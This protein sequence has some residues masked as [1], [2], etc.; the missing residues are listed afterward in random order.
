MKK[1]TIKKLNLNKTVISQLS[2]EEQMNVRGGQ[3]EVTTSFG[4]CTGFLC[5]EPISDDSGTCCTSAAQES[6]APTYTNPSNG[7]TVTNP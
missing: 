7:K 3:N 5:C 6:C 2:G 4:Q 1:K